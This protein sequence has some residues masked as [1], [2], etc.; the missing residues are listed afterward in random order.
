MDIPN[1]YKDILYYSHLYSSKIDDSFK[2]RFLGFECELNVEDG[3]FTE[4][5]FDVN[6]DKN[7][8]EGISKIKIFLVNKFIRHNILSYKDDN[9]EKCP[10]YVE[11]LKFLRTNKIDNILNENIR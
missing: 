6:I 11:Y 4:L 3:K 8:D 7:T 2:L 9:R 5:P 1:I 10:F